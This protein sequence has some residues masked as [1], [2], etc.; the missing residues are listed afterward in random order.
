MLD[1]ILNSQ[2]MTDVNINDIIENNNFYVDYKEKSD[3]KWK[4][5]FQMLRTQFNIIINV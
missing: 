5:K 3:L 1:M 4:K 2:K